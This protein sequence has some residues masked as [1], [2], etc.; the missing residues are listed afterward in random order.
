MSKKIRIETNQYKQIYY[1]SK[2]LKQPMTLIVRTAVGL[3]L[4]KLGLGQVSASDLKTP[5]K[6]K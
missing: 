6:G 2:E 4:K 5:Q 3:Y 1:L